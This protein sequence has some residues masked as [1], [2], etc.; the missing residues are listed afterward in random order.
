MIPKLVH[1]IW[2]GPKPFPEDAVERVEAWRRL[3]PDYQ[4][5]FWTEANI[6]F[7]PRFLRQAYGVRAYN[8][9]AN[10]ARMAALATYGGIYMDHD[11]ELLQSFDPLLGE[12]C[13][14]GFQ[15]ADGTA[16]DIVNNAIVGAEPGH[17]FILRVLAALNAMNGAHEVGSG[18]G[19]GLLSKLLREMGDPQ[20]SPEPLAFHGVT[21]FPP[22]YFYPYEWF[23]P[24]EP[25]CITP[26]T[27]AVHHWAH[28]WKRSQ[29]MLDVAKLRAWRAAAKFSPY[30]AST[31][32]RLRNMRQRGLVRE[33]AVKPGVRLAGP[34]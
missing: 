6:D 24:F 13:F 34:V 9:V 19:P 18:T 33:T 23:A 4:F 25:A 17:P 27:I 3:L 5:M 2:V 26:D 20:P 16:V 31:V 15:T 12:A 22:R 21:L 11:V 10:Y 30:A 29:R 28:T 8:R 14:A 32:M 7:S 1:Y